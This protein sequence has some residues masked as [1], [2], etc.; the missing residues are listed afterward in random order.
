MALVE[1]TIYKLFR[2]SLCLKLLQQFSPCKRLLIFPFTYLS[3]VLLLMNDIY[4]LN[5][6]KTL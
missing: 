5:N 4:L 3:Y 1:I 2:E 6:C